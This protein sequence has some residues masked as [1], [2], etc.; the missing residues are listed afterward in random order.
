VQA[1]QMLPKNRDSDLKVGAFMYQNLQIAT[2]LKGS[3]ASV[4]ATLLNQFC[5]EN[6]IN[7]AEIETYYRNGIRGL[8]SA[9]VDEEFNKVSFLLGNSNTFQIARSHNAVL[10]RNPQNGQYTL[11]Y[12]GAYTNNETR[13]I[14]ANSLE[15]IAS[16]MGR[17]TSDFDQTGI[18]AVRAQ[19][20]L[21][22]A[23]ARPRELEIT[24]TAVTNFFLTP[25]SN[26]YD[27][28]I[29]LYKTYLTQTYLR[30]SFLR[31]VE[32]LNPAIAM[33]MVDR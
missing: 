33:R 4:Y 27:A 16:E 25:N 13:T 1:A 17:R 28:M 19:A 9:V 14:T 23:V 22:P 32:G 7:K 12:G 2:F 18:N 10:I 30:G 24:K 21:I 29:S 5:T 20:A 15:T 8:V 31:T 6:R 11:N 26:T 3:N